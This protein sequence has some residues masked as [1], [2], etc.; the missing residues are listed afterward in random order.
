MYTYVTSEL[1]DIVEA[2]HPDQVANKRSICGHSMGGHGALTVFFKNPG[3]YASVSAFSPIC[4]PTTCPWGEKAFTNYLGSVNSGRAHDASVLARAATV[5]PDVPI[6]V[7]QG[8]ADSFLVGE[9]DQLQPHVLV[10]ACREAGIELDLRMHEGY[11]HSYFF[12]S[13]FIGDHLNFHAD[14]LGAGPRG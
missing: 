10:A 5:K 13:T 7:D 8:A 1:P 4:S 6:L 2:M 14:A 11:D 12:I 3:R 9:V